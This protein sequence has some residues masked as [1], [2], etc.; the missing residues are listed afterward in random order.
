[1][2]LVNCTYKNYMKDT[3]Y[4]NLVEAKIGH[5]KFHLKCREQTT[6]QLFHMIP[7]KN[8]RKSLTSVIF[9]VN[10]DEC[11]MENKGGGEGWNKNVLA[12]KHQKN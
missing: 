10:K 9:A 3:Y 7:C 12:G 8:Q 5:Q 4:N 1:M 6:E 2:F 11:F